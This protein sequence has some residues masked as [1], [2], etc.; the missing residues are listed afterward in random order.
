MDQ[1]FIEESDEK[2]EG[3]VIRINSLIGKILKVH[4]KH[5][6]IQYLRIQT[7]RQVL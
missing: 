2:I 1:I 4:F 6:R 7:Q 3:S 5:N